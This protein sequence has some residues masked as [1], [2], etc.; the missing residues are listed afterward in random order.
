MLYEKQ[1]GGYLD[2]LYKHRA[3]IE[4]GKP[5]GG[6]ELVIY[7]CEHQVHLHA[8]TGGYLYRGL[9]V[10]QTGKLAGVP[11]TD[12]W[13]TC[14]RTGHLSR[15]FFTQ[16]GGRTAPAPCR[17]HPAPSKLPIKQEYKDAIDAAATLGGWEALI[18][19]LNR[20][21]RFDPFMW[22]LWDLTCW[23]QRQ[24]IAGEYAG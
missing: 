11:R 23:Y 9:D 18:A 19:M 3:W 4:R 16:H 20:H 2:H 10:A 1:F 8:A 12:R 17:M 6:A 21:M 7:V 22:R 24:P 14:P 15:H 5:G 13:A